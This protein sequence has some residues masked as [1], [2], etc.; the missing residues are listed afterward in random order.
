MAQ[1][2]SC[3][4]SDKAHTQP[5]SVSDD[6]NHNKRPGTDAPSGFGSS[7]RR[8]F[9]SRLGSVGLVATAAPLARAVSTPTPE[10]SISPASNS[11]MTGVPI[12]LKIN[13]TER[14]L[15]LDPR[16]TLLDCLREN[17]GLTGTKKGV[18]P[19]PMRRLHGPCQRA[20]GKFLSVVRGDA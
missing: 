3:V 10:P 4:T 15:Q 14:H 6:T 20:P 9:L 5:N 12:T 8:A 2:K 17:I 11:R 7:S 13:G 19:R 1:S 18:R 16:T